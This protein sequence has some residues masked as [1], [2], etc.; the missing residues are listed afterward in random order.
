M[1]RL[2]EVRRLLRERPGRADLESIARQLDLG[3]DEVDAMVDYW[4]RRGE[5]KRTVFGACAATVCGMPTR[6]GLTGHR[7]TA[8]VPCSGGDLAVTRPL[9]LWSG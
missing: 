3:R 5:L 8:C 1:S 9:G 2:R 7:T 4:V 6:P